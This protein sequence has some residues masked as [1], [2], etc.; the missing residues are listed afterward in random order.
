MAL[1]SW[2]QEASGWL[3]G[4][5]SQNAFERITRLDCAES[6]DARSDFF[7]LNPVHYARAQFD[8]RRQ[9]QDILGIFHSHPNGAAHPSA[10]DL[11][12]SRSMFGRDRGWLEI[13]AAVN[14]HRRL[15]LSCWRL[16]DGVYRQCNFRVS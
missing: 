15:D 11:S 4:P 1:D 6:S 12:W 8:A 16:D 13:I 7:V 9:G 10:T 5:R 3:I 2:P 14:E